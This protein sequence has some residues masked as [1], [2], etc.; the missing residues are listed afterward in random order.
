LDV[1]GRDPAIFYDPATAQIEELAGDGMA[2]GVD[3]DAQY[4]VNERDN[5]NRGSIIVLGTDG[6]WESRNSSGEMLGKEVISEIIRDNAVCG[7]AEILEAVI[8]KIREFQGDMKSE[9]D[10]TLVVV[11][12]TERN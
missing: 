1:A 5:F 7:A 11:K 4:A 6:I 2:L 9:D 12:A 10:L 3:P 8:T